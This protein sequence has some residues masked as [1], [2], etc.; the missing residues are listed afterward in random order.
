MS[1]SGQGHRF[2]RA[3]TEGSNPSTGTSRATIVYWLG[4]LPFKQGKPGRNRLVVPNKLG[5]YTME[6]NVADAKA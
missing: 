6:L 5:E 3:G 1:S 2:L 4:F